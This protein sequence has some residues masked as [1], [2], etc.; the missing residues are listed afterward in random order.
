[1][2]AWRRWR[3]ENRDQGEPSARAIDTFP[4][5]SGPVS[6]IGKAKLKW[7]GSPRSHRDSTLDT[8]NSAGRSPFS[9][10]SVRTASG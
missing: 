3:D 8:D 2:Q 4:C 10:D 5:V 6:Q 7:M 1:M 9:P